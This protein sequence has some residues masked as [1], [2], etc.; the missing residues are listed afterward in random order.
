MLHLEM[1]LLLNSL[2]Q[3]KEAIQ[4]LNS[5]INLLLPIIILWYHVLLT[6]IHSPYF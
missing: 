4:L 2:T 6:Y 3:A 5:T 1:D